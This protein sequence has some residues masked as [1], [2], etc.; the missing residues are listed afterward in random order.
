[1]KWSD[2]YFNRF[3]FTNKTN[4]HTC[5]NNATRRTRAKNICEKRQPT[6][7][8]SLWFTFSVKDLWGKQFTAVAL[9]SDLLSLHAPLSCRSKETGFRAQDP[10]WIHQLIWC[11]PQ[12]T[13]TTTG[14]TGPASSINSF[15]LLLRPLESQEDWPSCSQSGQKCCPFRVFVWCEV[16]VIVLLA[17]QW[18]RPSIAVPSSCYS[19]FCGTVAEAKHCRWCGF[20]SVRCRRMS[21]PFWHLQVAPALANVGSFFSSNVRFSTGKAKPT[22]H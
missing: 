15:L 7:C 1:M 22:P 2:P 9:L 12:A 5:K 20:L 6:A 10:P 11:K 19:A 4:V 21:G 14:R 8:R 3:T 17:A 13:R 18:L 16:L